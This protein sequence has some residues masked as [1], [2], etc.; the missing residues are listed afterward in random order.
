MNDNLRKQISE[1]LIDIRKRATE[2]I[3][4]H[5]R[6]ADILNQLTIERFLAEHARDRQQQQG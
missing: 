4:I 1:K 5:N 2:L 6:V 3:E